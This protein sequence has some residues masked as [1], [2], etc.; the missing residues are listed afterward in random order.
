MTL[1]STGGKMFDPWPSN[2]T[3]RKNI[4][5]HGGRIGKKVCRKFLTL[6][7]GAPMLKRLP[8]EII[9]Q[10]LTMAMRGSNYN[11]DSHVLQTYNS[12]RNA[13]RFWRTVMDSECVR[14]MLLRVYGPY[15][16]A[17]PSNLKDAKIT[18]RN[19]QRLIKKVGSSS[20]LILPLSEILSHR[21]CY[22]AWLELSPLVCGKFLI[23]NV[24]WKAKK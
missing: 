8:P 14:S 11:L 13:C 16:E 24:F 9:E 23:E 21:N 15:K 5:K 2:N 19:V 7:L 17:L 6:I 22:N 20:G 12:L 4:N 1:A 18:V 10:I 3:L